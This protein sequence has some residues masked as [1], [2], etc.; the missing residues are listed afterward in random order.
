MLRTGCLRSGVIINRLLVVYPCGHI[1]TGT[2][3]VDVAPRD[4]VADE[5]IFVAQFAP[6]IEHDAVYG[7]VCAADRPIDLFNFA[8]G[9]FGIIFPYVGAGSVS[10]ST[11]T[12]RSTVRPISVL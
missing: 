5:I 9:Q 1:G 2:V 6:L 10:F 7:H 4:V 12:S 11:V 3:F 8:I